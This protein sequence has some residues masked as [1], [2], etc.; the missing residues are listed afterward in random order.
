M[1]IQYLIENEKDWFNCFP[2]AGGATQWTDGHS[3]K[4][5]AK[6]VTSENFEKSLGSALNLII[7][8][9]PI[10]Q[11]FP[12][13]LTYFDNNSRGP[14]H[15][16]LACI[17]KVNGINKALCFEAKVKESPDK[18]LQKYDS[19]FT[20]GQK[21]RANNLCKLFFGKTYEENKEEL[22]KIYYQILTG[23][24][25][26]IV[27]AAENN[28]SE[29]YFIIYQIIPQSSKNKPSERII[30]K[31]KMAITDF[32]DCYKGPVIKE[33]WKENT[34]VADLGIIPMT[35]NGK[36]ISSHAHIVYTEKECS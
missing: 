17:T 7:D 33:L 16:D 9:I 19:D 36:I 14:R 24:A 12:E 11:A 13:R 22:S 3:A 32:I 21:E 1:K 35:I 4:E 5:F 28:V 18:Q 27:F 29:C 20:A 15:H 30:K 31:H 10:N 25:G 2:P 6:I 26:T 23:L 34:M 8:D